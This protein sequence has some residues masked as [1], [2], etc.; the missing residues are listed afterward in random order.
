VT[1]E[2]VSCQLELHTYQTVLPD[3]KYDPFSFIFVEIGMSNKVTTT[4]SLV[5]LIAI[6]KLVNPLRGGIGLEIIPLFV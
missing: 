6:T 5:Q 2:R 3:F 1:W 4:P